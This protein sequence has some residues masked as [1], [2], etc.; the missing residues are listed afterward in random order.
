M[1]NKVILVGRAGKDPVLHTTK[2]DKKVV[3]F[4]IATWENYKDETSETGWRTETE[5]HNVVVWGQSAE[6][7]AKNVKKGS[8]VYVEGSIRTRSYDDKEGVK[9]WI[10]EVSGFARCLDPKKAEAKKDE[11][12]IAK[13]EW[14]GKR[15]TKAM[16]NINDLPQ[17]TKEADLVPDDSEAPF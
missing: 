14:N 6:T 10:T 13:E 1:I 15:E 12:P 4:T 5:W 11:A 8:M 3:K 2:T 17:N 9:K 16:S 7:L